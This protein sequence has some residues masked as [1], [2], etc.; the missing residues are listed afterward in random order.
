MDLRTNWAMV[1][2]LVLFAGFLLWAS[3]E[4]PRDPA[5]WSQYGMNDLRGH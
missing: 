1:V 5:L 2:M 3:Q 4:G